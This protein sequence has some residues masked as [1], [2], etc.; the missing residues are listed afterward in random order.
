MAASVEISS[1]DNINYKSKIKIIFY[2]LIV[3]FLFVFAFMSYYP[4]GDK[5]KVFLKSNLKGTGCNPDFDEIRMEWIMPKLVIS[6]LKLPA[7][8]LGRTGDTLEFSHVTLNY[9][10]INFAPFGLPFRLDTELYGQ[11]I[12]VYFVQGLGQRMIRMKDQTIAL[13]RLQPL[14]GGNFKLAGNVTVDLNL[15]VGSNNLMKGLS[16]I[17]ES[18]DLQIP[19]QSIQGFT[20]PNLKINT[21]RVEAN[22]EAPPR[23]NV[24]KLILGDAD[25]PLRA[26]FKGRIDLQEGAVA[27]SPINL[28]G[29]VAFSETFKQQLPLIDMMFQSFTQKDGFYQIRLGGTLGAPKPSAP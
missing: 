10:L 4:I 19:S 7:S 20:A 16:L 17:A 13:S 23:I 18:K 5:L 6:D 1:L 14:L 24:D 28:A 9:Q 22:S 2:I 25:S 26:N 8:C 11:P 12:T 15:T 21:L 3:F 29:E 27:F